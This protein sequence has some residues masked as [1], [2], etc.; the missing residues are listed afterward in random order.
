MVGVMGEY[1]GVEGDDPRPPCRGSAAERF[2]EERLFLS[3]IVKVF[4]C[5]IDILARVAEGLL[6][7]GKV[8]R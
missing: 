8:K 1:G 6:C 5:M 4:C 7:A 2:M 3:A